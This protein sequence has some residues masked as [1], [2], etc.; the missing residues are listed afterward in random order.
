MEGSA[1][2]PEDTLVQYIV[3]RKDLKMGSG[4]LIAQGAHASSAALWLSKDTPTTL[5]YLSSLDTMHKIV[6]EGASNDQLLALSESLTSASILHKLWVEQPEN[7]A[8]ALATAP[9]QRSIL[10]PLFAGFKLLR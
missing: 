6:L 8:T 9:Y 2:P 10:K 3:V 4:A 7:I 5:A 1:S